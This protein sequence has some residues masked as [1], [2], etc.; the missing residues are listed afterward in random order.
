M[1]GEFIIFCYH[2]K[3]LRSKHQLSQKQM[4]RIMGISVK[5]LSTLEA[6]MMP[7]RLRVTVIFRLSEH[8]HLEPRQLFMPDEL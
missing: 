2:V 3:A 5:S 8:F 6:G 4:S 1:S 7:P